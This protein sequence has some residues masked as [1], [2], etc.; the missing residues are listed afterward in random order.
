MRSLPNSPILTSTELLLFAALQ[1]LFDPGWD[2][3][4]VDRRE[5]RTIDK[6]HGCAREVHHLVA[7]TN[8]AGSVDWPGMAQAFRV[9]RH[10][11][12]QGN[13]LRA[14]GCFTVAFRLRYHSQYPD[15]AIGLVAAPLSTRPHAHTP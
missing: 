1:L 2:V 6:G 4:L 8:L 10:W 13:P 9:E 5:A 11:Q 12:A 15:Q 3:S 7:S 14:A